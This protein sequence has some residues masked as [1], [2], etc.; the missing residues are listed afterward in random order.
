MR[1][2]RASS[3]TNASGAAEGLLDAFDAG[4]VAELRS[5][6]AEGRITFDAARLADLILRY[7]ES[8]R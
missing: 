1:E 5:A 8:G 3:D 2:A 4:R 6:L 7:H